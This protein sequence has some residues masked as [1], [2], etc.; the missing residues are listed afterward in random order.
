MDK[1]QINQI[2]ENLSD[3]EQVPDVV[4]QLTEDCKLLLKEVERLEARHKADQKAV[5]EANQ[6]A[7]TYM[8]RCQELYDE[9]RNTLKN[10]STECIVE[11]LKRRDK[12]ISYHVGL[13]GTID[14]HVSGPCTEI[15]VFE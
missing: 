4:F 13:G 8:K 10:C 6:L 15:W 5:E 3:A 12:I 9:N 7:E 2:A 14:A 11:E 1:N